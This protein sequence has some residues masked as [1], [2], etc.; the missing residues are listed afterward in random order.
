MIVEVFFGSVL[1]FVICISRETFEGE[2]KRRAESDWMNEIGLGYQDSD[3]G[4]V[5]IVW[6][7]FQ[8]RVHYL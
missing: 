1:I 4:I 5:G 3:H 8:T 6:C 2:I 7:H